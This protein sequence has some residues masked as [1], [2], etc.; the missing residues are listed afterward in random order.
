MNAT[1]GKRQGFPAVEQTLRRL[2][3]TETIKV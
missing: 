3:V 2:K 1:A